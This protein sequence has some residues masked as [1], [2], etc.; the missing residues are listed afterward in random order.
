MNII[1]WVSYS[2]ANRLGEIDKYQN[3]HDTKR[4]PNYVYH[5]YDKVY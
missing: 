1:Q 3:I 2:W 5:Y 4:T